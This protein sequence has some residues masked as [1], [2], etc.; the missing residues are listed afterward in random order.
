MLEAGGPLEI[1]AFVQGQHRA[2]QGQHSHHLSQRQRAIL[3]VQRPTIHK[4]KFGAVQ[5]LYTL[6]PLGPDH[7]VHHK[8]ARSNIL[9]GPLRSAKGSLYQSAGNVPG[10]LQGHSI[11]AVQCNQPTIQDRQRRPLSSGSGAKPNGK[12][13]LGHHHAFHRGQANGGDLTIFGVVPRQPRLLI[14]QAA[15]LWHQRG[16]LCE[17]AK[18]TG[19]IA[20]QNHRPKLGVLC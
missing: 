18:Q 19:H 10:R 14:D 12:P 8:R 11:F 16:C 7:R 9:R 1:E 5:R 3:H 20:G 15:T 17:H 13:A 2:N 4:T 6:D